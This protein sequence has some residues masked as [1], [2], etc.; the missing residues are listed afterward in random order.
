MSSAEPR[1]FDALCASI[2]DPPANGAQTSVA[3]VYGL[4]LA[5]FSLLHSVLLSSLE[6]PAWI[7]G[8][9]TPETLL[10][11]AVLCSRASGTAPL[12]HPEQAAETIA[13]HD[14]AEQFDAWET[15]L[16]RCTASPRTK[17]RESSGGGLRAP[18]ELIVA[19]FLMRTLGIS[20]QRAWTMKYGLAQWYFEASCEQETGESDIITEADAA[21]MEAALTEAGQ[22]AERDKCRRMEDLMRHRARRLARCKTDRGRANVE[23]WFIERL[24]TFEDA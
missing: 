9:V 4:A 12:P 13:A 18:A 24:R 22:A 23:R 19:V 17:R 20:E 6:N 11:A 3:T 16:A 7:G 5:P 21:E 10:A 8:S 14:F 15:Y 1:F 2:D